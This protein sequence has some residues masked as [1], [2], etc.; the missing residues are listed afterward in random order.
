MTSLLPILIVGWLGVAYVLFRKLPGPVA[1]LA[2]VIAGQLF[3][4][5]IRADSIEPGTP[6]ALRAAGRQVHQGQHDRL[7]PVVRLACHRLAAVADRACRGGTTC[8]WRRGA[9]ARFSRPSSTASARS[10]GSTKAATGRRTRLSSGAC[11]TGAAGCTSARPTDCGPRPRRSSSAALIYAPLCLLEL[12]LSPQLHRWVYGYHQHDFVQTMR[13]GG[14]R[15]MV[16]MEHGL[17]VSFWMAAAALTAF[18]LWHERTFRVLGLH[19]LRCRSG[20]C[21]S[22]PGWPAVVLLSHSAG[23]VVLGAAGVAS[24]VA[25]RRLRTAVPLL[26]L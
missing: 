9:S 6:V 23:A 18:W 26:G 22:R 4:P 10:A 13:D 17:M 12:R 24:L 1:V 14:Y 16:F 19:R 11:P 2:V 7:R 5:E 3:L 21:G 20:W 25:A 8:R 15:P